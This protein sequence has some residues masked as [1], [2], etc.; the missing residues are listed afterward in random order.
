VHGKFIMRF[1]ISV[2]TI[3]M[4]IVAHAIVPPEVNLS[5]F[6]SDLKFAG[7]VSLVE[8]KAIYTNSNEICAVSYKAKVMQN[9]R[10]SSKGKIISLHMYKDIRN[11]G[12]EFFEVGESYF[13]YS[14]SKDTHRFVQL[15]DGLYR[16]PEYPEECSGKDDSKY[17]YREFSGK[18]NYSGSSTYITSP[19]LD[20]IKGT[21]SVAK[22]FYSLDGYESVTKSISLFQ[23]YQENLEYLG[24]EIN[25]FI[26]FFG[27]GL[28]AP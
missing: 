16:F 3:F 20:L 2:F 21:D 12:F 23:A 22:V 18:I 26:K 15:S 6:K 4:T 25:A 27:S 28:N 1:I 11:L 17:V 5:D 19:G 24:F 9:I 8:A 14:E 10:G 13:I 7:V